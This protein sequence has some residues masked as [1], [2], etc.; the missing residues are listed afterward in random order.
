MN[1]PSSCS[2]KRE[3]TYWTLWLRMFFCFCFCIFFFNVYFVLLFWGWVVQRWINCIIMREHKTLLWFIP[4]QRPSLPKKSI[5][6]A[7]PIYIWHSPPLHLR[8][9]WCSTSP[10]QWNMLQSKMTWF[11]AQ[12]NLPT[13]K[14]LRAGF[15]SPGVASQDEI[16]DLLLTQGCSLMVI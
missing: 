12:G 2:Q 5:I 16:R 14:R 7:T 13:A 1:Y 8:D 9:C 4:W 3:D 10:V 6:S 11:A 15:I